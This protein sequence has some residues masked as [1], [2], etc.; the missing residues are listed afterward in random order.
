VSR[1]LAIVAPAVPLDWLAAYRRYRQRRWRGGAWFAYWRLRRAGNLAARSLALA[2]LLVLMPALGAEN[3][4]RSR[5]S[6]VVAAATPWALL[7]AERRRDVV[8]AR[9]AIAALSTA[10]CVGSSR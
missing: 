9:C 10:A 1:L 8:W 3:T 7:Q 4:G 2:S 5:T 6:R